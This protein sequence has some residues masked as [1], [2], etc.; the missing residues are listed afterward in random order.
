MFRYALRRL[1]W[2]IPTLLATSFVLFL[3]TTLAPEPAPPAESQDG[4]ESEAF[5][6]ARRARFLDLPAL[7]NPDPQDVRS[8]ARAA[9]ARVASGDPRQQVV[10]A[11]ELVRLGG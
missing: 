3:V 8:R 6:Q 5:D 4:R 7:F 2:A 9:V 11:R 10:A 1:L